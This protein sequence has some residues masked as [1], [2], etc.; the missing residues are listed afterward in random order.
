M[1]SRLEGIKSLFSIEVALNLVHAAKTS[2]G[3]AAVFIS[4]GG[5]AGGEAKEQCEAIFVNL[6]RILGNGHIKPG[7]DKASTIYHTIIPEKSWT[8]TTKALHH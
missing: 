6:L 7:F 3:R 1:T 8:I 4:L 5:Q 2:L